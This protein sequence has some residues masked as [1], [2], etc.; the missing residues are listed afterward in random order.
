LKEGEAASKGADQN[1][2]EISTRSGR[3]NRSIH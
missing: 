1:K 3:K 2:T